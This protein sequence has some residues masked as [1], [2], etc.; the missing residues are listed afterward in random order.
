[1]PRVR[2]HRQHLTSLL[3]LI[4]PCC[5]HGVTDLS[6]GWRIACAG[7]CAPA[8]LQVSNPFPQRAAFTTAIS[9]T[10]RSRACS[11]RPAFER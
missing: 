7:V 5:E 1:M 10:A 11:R 8:L 3:P 6:G 9:S 2:A 4:R